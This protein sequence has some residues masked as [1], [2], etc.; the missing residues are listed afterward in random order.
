[1]L[2]KVRSRLNE[3]KDNMRHF[4]LLKKQPFRG[5]ELA[6]AMRDSTIRGG[7]SIFNMKH[8]NRE[9][10]L[11]IKGL[12]GIAS[13][14]IGLGVV[15]FGYGIGTESPKK[16]ASARANPIA[17]PDLRKPVRAM[18]VALGDMIFFAQDLG[19]SATTAK[20]NPADAGKIAARI[21]NQLQGMREIYRIEVAKNPTLAGSVI[22]Q[23]S[24]AP[25]GEVHQVREI[26]ARLHDAD[27][28]KAIVAEAEK[29]SF[30]EIVSENLNVTCPLLF[31]HEGMDITTLVQWEKSIGSSGEKPVPARLAGDFTPTQQSK[32][33]EIPLPAGPST[34]S[35]AVAAAK[36]E[37]AG[38]SDGKIFQIKYAT[39]LRKEPN[40]SA[41]SLITFTIGTKVTVLRNQGDWLEVRSTDSGPTGFIRKEFVTPVEVAHK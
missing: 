4:Y 19:F 34:K 18:N 3:Y 41:V 30:A 36:T 23:F 14:V 8:L 15:Y 13:C 17:Q 40:F 7:A 9:W 38:K 31:V 11:G 6:L 2:L 39:S 26:S 24:I 27:F 32:A 1:M 10:P 16:E 37:T 12:V 33:A 22:L 5:T 21:E 25:S 29:W 28:M 20:D 35:A